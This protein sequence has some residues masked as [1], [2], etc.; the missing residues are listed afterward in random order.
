MLRQEGRKLYLT[1]QGKTFVHN[2][3]I[4]KRNSLTSISKKLK[5]SRDSLTRIVKEIYGEDFNLRRKF[6]LDEN[7]F[8]EINSNEKAY[9]LGFLA[10][11]G[12]INKNELVLELQESDMEHLIKFGNA[13]SQGLNVRKII[14][15]HKEKDFIHYRVSFRSGRTVENLNKQGVF[16]NKSLSLS[17]PNL[18]K[19]YIPYWILGYMDGDGCLF[20]AKN[21]LK[22]NFTGT[23]EVLVWIKEYFNSNNQIIQAHKCKN[24]TFSFTLEVDLTDLFLKNIKYETLDYVLNRKR[25]IYINYIAPL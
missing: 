6:Y 16:Q 21:R 18:K 7:Y 15:H 8:V 1:E 23:K 3:L 17:P 25:S 4:I 20:K 13:I 9:W 5:I 19:Q 2:E 10:A 22:I 14:H 11:D 12:Y 24:N